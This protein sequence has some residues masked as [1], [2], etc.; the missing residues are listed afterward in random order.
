MLKPALVLLSCAVAAHAYCNSMNHPPFNYGPRTSKAFPPGWNGLSTT[1]VRGWR[2]WYAYYTHMDEGM[3]R[4][5]VDALTSKN[6]TVKGWE[7]KVSLCDL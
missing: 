3:I 2:S 5:V 7:G 4:E 1:P 6:R